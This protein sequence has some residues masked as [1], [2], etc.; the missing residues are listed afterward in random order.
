MCHAQGKF[1]CCFIGWLTDQLAYVK[2]DLWTLANLTPDNL[3]YDDVLDFFREMLS[4]MIV[5]WVSGYMYK[6]SVGYC[7][8]ISGQHKSTQIY[9]FRWW[10]KLK[11]KVGC[12]KFRKILVYNITKPSLIVYKG[13]IFNKPSFIGNKP[14]LI[15]NKPSPVVNKSSPG[16]NKSSLISPNHHWLST[17]HHWTSTKKS[18]KNHL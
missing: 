11:D 1:G 10:T 16:V 8:I 14:S 2:K 15:L 7:S 3:K 13:S 12:V 18:V 9:V 4:R 17:N 5:H 6:R